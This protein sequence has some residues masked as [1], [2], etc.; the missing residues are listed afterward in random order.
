MPETTEILQ[1]HYS[2]LGYLS[3]ACL[4][5][6]PTNICKAFIDHKSRMN[7][8]FHMKIFFLDNVSQ[9]LSHFM[10]KPTN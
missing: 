7:I 2:F 8:L 6:F 3:E 5:N 9:N 4:F 10:T 1:K